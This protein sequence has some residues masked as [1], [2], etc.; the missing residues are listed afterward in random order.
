MNI[1]EVYKTALPE[2]K[3]K[4]LNLLTQLADDMG[5]KMWLVG[6]IVRDILLE[7]PFNDIDILIEYDAIIFAKLA[8]KKYSNNLKILAQNDKFK[9]AKLNFTISNISFEA[10]IASTRSEVYEYPSAL[11]ILAETSVPLKKDISRR[12]F[13]VNSLAMS[14]N[15]KDFGQ[16]YDETLLG[17]QDLH[18]KLIRI[19][20]PDSFMDDP[21]RIL[22]GLKYRE[23]LGFKLEEDTLFLQEDCL[24]SGK[25][26]DDCQERIKKELIETFNLNSFSV[27]DKFISENI[28]RLIV[29]QINK[30]DI[31]SGTLIN[32]VINNYADKIETE[33]IWL[34]YLAVIFSLAPYDLAKQNIEKLS[35]TK[36]ENKILADFFVMKNSLEKLSELKEKYDIYNYFKPF[37]N[38]AIVAFQCVIKKPDE[39]EKIHLYF[40]KLIGIKLSVT[41]NDIK[42]F[43][44]ADGEIYKSILNSTLQVKMNNNLSEEEEKKYF[45]EICK[46][47]K[48]YSKYEE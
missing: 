3:K 27:F 20:H 24:Q 26:D 46:S 8:E 23:K 5:V 9:T 11:P 10:D 33:N 18:K 22:R 48:T 21:S 6:G 39:V 44:I 35:L 43:G 15:S 40:N 37:S 32:Q 38:E 45:K 12:D 25:F 17:L 2:A 19:L 31:P 41:G 16:I 14:L 7:R 13:T 30:K 1:L 28:Y 29:S 47:I 42:S 4:A 36:K 34:I